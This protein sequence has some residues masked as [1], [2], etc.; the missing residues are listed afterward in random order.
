MSRIVPFEKCIA[1]PESSL[2]EHLL[3][4]KHSMEYFLR[5]F[6]SVTVRLS[7][8][9]GV[10]HDLAKAHVEWQAYIQ[11]PAIKKGPN[12]SACGAFLFS[13]LGFHLLESNGLW[14]EHKILWLWFIQDIRSHHGNLGDLHDDNWLKKYEWENFDLEG[15][16]QFL[17]EQY[18][19]LHYMK[20]HEPALTRWITECG[21]LLEDIYDELDLEYEEWEPLPIMKR[22]QVWRQM[23]T[24]LIAGDRFHVKE[25]TP[26]WL[27]KQNFNQFNKAMIDFSR[28][29]SG[30]TLSVMRIKAQ[31]EIIHQLEKEP[32]HTFYTL[33]MPTGYGK[34]ITSLKMA[35]WFGEHQGFK[36]IVYVAPYLSILEQ[37]A[38]VIENLFDTEVLQHHSLAI[39]DD[40]REQRTSFSQLAMESWAH[41]LVC[42]SFQQLC[43]AIFPGRAQDVLRRAFLKDSVIII[44]E[45]QIFIP[46][47]WNLF[48]CGVE[49]LTELIH[50]K[51]IFLSATMPPFHYGLTINPMKLVV[52]GSVKHDRYQVVNETEKQ[53][54][55]TVLDL[56]EK[57]ERQ[58]QALI[59][60]TV[61]DAFLSFD[62]LIK[63]GKNGYL[64]H[65]LMTPVHKKARI[66]MISNLLKEKQ[67]RPLYVVSTQV[68]EAGVDLSFQHVARALSTLPSIVQAAGRTNR[69]MEDRD[70][71]G[72][73]TVFPF[74]RSGNIDTRSMIYPRN[75]QKI[76]DRILQEKQIYTES[77]MVGL[78][79]MYY[80]EMF[81]QNTYEAALV[82]IKDAY[83]GRWQQL[84][85]VQPFNTNYLTLPIFVPYEPVLDQIDNKV[86]TLK[87][88]FQVSNPEQIYNKYLDRHFIVNL[89]FEERKMFMI[90]FNYYV[91]NVP[92]K[93]ALSVVSK[94]DYLQNK[95]P[96]LLDTEAYDEVYGLKIGML[97]DDPIW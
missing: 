83:E 56:L 85:G 71:K 94:D 30:E 43:K 5:D 33:E 55:E 58:T 19:E 13:Y 31:Q 59:V 76:T 72:L 51:V 6:D 95:V 65:G 40:A 26:Q 15:I 73:L 2:A 24:S 37:N 4:V 92:V 41:S 77:E 12:H 28:K 39:L 34:T 17:K 45:P 89:S 74:Y 84:S 50:L 47:I 81:R 11:S 70:E 64:V 35:N 53:S 21:Y 82:K 36:K 88:R 96:I 25:V 60:N 61:K 69:H 8:L 62:N 38:S 16:E 86:L 87:K 29:H 14:D 97:E 46:E 57:N 75:L 44:D 1:R 23:T 9:A 49:A 91:L 80:S 27:D 54:E 48:L 20:L 78:V 93:T 63:R 67:N 22:L 52:K 18:K 42:T 90:L 7:G 3:F 79:N 68:L 10:C 66:K 32:N